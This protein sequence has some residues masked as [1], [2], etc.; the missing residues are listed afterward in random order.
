MLI[1]AVVFAPGIDAKTTA[2][3]EN[4]LQGDKFGR[5]LIGLESYPLFRLFTTLVSANWNLDKL[6][7]KA[8]A[9]SPKDRRRLPVSFGYPKSRNLEQ[10]P[11]GYASW[12]AFWVRARCPLSKCAVNDFFSRNR[13][14][15]SATLGNG[16]P[17]NCRLKRP[18]VLFGFLSQ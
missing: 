9:G 18:G 3:R 13:C 6:K 11:Y 12:A 4:H 5:K 10:S 2:N 7:K 16:L 15:S 1:L 14:G 8:K 17:I